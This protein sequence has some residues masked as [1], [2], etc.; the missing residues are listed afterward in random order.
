MRRRLPPLKTLPAFEIAASQLSFSAAAEE[1]HVTHGAI[2]RQVKALED[3]LGVPLFRRLHRHIALTPAGEALLP[4]VRTAFQVLETSTVQLAAAPR[5]GPLV[6]SCL[7]TFMMRWLIPKLY[8]FHVLHPKIEVRLSASYAP[9]DFAGDGIDV[10]IRLGAPPWPRGMQVQPFLE[11][12]VGPVCS[13]ELLQTHRLDEPADLVNHTLLHTESRPQGWADWL[14]L[15]GGGELDVRTGLRFEHT[16]FMLEA[17]VSNLGIGIGSYA[18]VEP[19][20]KSGRL[21][22]PFGFVPS[23]RSYYVMHPVGTARLAKIKAFRS[24]LLEVAQKQAPPLGQTA[25]SGARA[26]TV[27]AAVTS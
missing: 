13:P 22:A 20:L 27:T 12:R 15:V 4:A 21:V 5:Q 18:L 25:D 14:G 26:Q 17:A 16:Y 7:A 9:I 8:A 23:G 1:L 19:D 24:W 6:I 11:D 3:Y 10:A 2:S